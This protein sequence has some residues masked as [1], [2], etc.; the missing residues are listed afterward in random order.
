MKRIVS[1]FESFVR[2][3]GLEP[4]NN[5]SQRGHW[6]QLTVRTARTG[7]ALVWAILHPQVNTRLTITQ[8]TRCH[9]T[10]FL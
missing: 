9:S 8:M 1:H 3:S 7:D 5:I 6:K 4:F 2:S 10:A